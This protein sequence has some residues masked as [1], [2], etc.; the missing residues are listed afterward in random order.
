MN[1]ANHIWF[2]SDTHFGHANII[3]HCAR[4]YRNAG[5]MDDALV[6]HWNSRVGVDDEV[7]HLGDLF[8]NMPPD[9]L[10]ALRAR[11]NGRI[12][13][14]P[15][16][17]DHPE[18]LLSEGL[19]DSV[20]PQIHELVVQPATAKSRTTLVLCH[21]PLEEWNRLHRGAIH[22]HGHCHG[23]LPARDLRR[24]DVGVDVHQYRPIALKEILKRFR[25][26]ESGQ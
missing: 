12:H 14:V 13:L 5:H 1:A 3:Q 8:W 4:P 24:L 2:T 16:N 10:R 23:R 21:Y 18:T 7:F 6:A 9:A 17:H 25:A 15:G 20:L 26:E 11:L 22:L 19:V